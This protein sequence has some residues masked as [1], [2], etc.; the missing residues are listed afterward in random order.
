MGFDLK[1]GDFG[2]FGF[3]GISGIKK[4]HFKNGQTEEKYNCLRYGSGSTSSSE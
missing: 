2:T 3:L 4:R 1:T